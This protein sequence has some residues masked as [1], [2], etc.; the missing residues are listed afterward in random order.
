MKK[1]NTK[2]KMEKENKIKEMLTVSSNVIYTKLTKKG[3]M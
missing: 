3:E 2:V 1:K